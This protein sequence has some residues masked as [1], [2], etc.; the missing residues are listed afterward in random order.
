MFKIKPLNKR[1]VFLILFLVVFIAAIFLVPLIVRA[2][3][4]L[5]QL[6]PSKIFF[7][8]F[9][10]LLLKLIS[11]V[12]KF[13][14]V[15]IRLLV[16][17]A[18][19]NDF[20]NSPAVSKGWI[21]IRDIFN[22]LLVLILLVIAFSTVL[23]IEKYSYKRLLGGFFLAAILVN[24]SKLICGIFIDI[25]QIL[26]LT[27]V[28]AF[29]SVGEGNMAELLGLSSLLNFA[30]TTK[31]ESIVA[32]SMGALFLGLV[33]VIIALVVISVITIILVFR[34]VIL[35]F[36]VLLSPLAF[37]FN[38]LPDTKRYASQWWQKF[39]SQV[40]IGPIL[41][42][43]LWLSLAM[44]TEPGLANNNLYK[45]ITPQGTEVEGIISASAQEGVEEIS[46]GSTEAGKPLLLCW[47]GL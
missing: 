38:I 2:Q 32:E 8:I 26:M 9:G 35:W 30:D 7:N 22:M 40:I 21:I 13:V 23:N 27:F 31:G 46:V 25:S 3:A 36:L 45:S 15:M 33:M 18:Q 10:N 43:F 14:T 34:I 41:A 28:N 37:M 47:L 6:N 11:F 24:F 1:K 17:V 16:A 39:G 19:Y 42:F 44:V 12:G 29:K 20:T 4:D 5:P